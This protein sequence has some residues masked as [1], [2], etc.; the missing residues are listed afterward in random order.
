MLSIKNILTKILIKLKILD[1]EKFDKTG[2]TLTGSI[3]INKTNNQ[4]AEG[5]SIKVISAARDEEAGNGVSLLA[6]ESGNVGIYNA[7]KE[8]WDF[9]HS[10]STDKVTIPYLSF[11]ST[12]TGTVA[13]TFNGANTKQCRLYKIGKIVFMSMALHYTNASSTIAT[14]TTMFTIPTDYRPV[15]ETNI[16]AQAGVK[17]SSSV[18]NGSA[19]CQLKISA[20][21]AITQGYSSSIYSLYAFGMWE[22]A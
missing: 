3:V 19:T 22:T 10:A 9:V 14:N 18:T 4:T 8:G 20:A 11:S 13:S 5:A 1:D 6:A 7:Q 15:E 12:S 21:G 2:G 17:L 16:L